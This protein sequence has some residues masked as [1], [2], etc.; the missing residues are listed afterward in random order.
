ML[1]GDFGGGAVPYQFLGKN[2]AFCFNIFPNGGRSVLFKQVVEIGF[3]NI[4]FL[5]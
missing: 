5:A 2:Q 1:A 4:K 3:A